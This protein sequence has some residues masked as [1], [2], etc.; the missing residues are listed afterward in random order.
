MEIPPM[1]DVLPPP[2]LPPQEKLLLPRL[3]PPS[4]VFHN[5]R[6]YMYPHSSFQWRSLPCTTCSPLPS[7]PPKKN[8]S[9]RACTPRPPYSIINA[10][11]CIRIP[12]SNGDP[13]HVRR[14]PPSR[15][16]R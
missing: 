3:H 5:K 6:M 4:A 9:S 13:S 10:C 7:C 16:A 11:I 1:Y 8:F 14:A 2:E 15:V 12:L